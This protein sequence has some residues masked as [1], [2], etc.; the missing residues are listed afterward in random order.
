MPIYQKGKKAQTHKNIATG[1]GPFWQKIANRDGPKWQ[2]IAKKVRPQWQYFIRR[3]N[4][5]EG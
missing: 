3:K 2:K 4:G 5:K 1:D